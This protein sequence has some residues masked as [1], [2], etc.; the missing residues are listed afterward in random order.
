MLTLL[1]LSFLKKEFKILILEFEQFE[2]FDKCD[3]IQVKTK[4]N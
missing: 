3:E 1:S 2:L 4:N